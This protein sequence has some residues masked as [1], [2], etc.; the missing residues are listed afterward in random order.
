M[1]IGTISDLDSEGLFGLIDCDDGRLV[2]FNLWDIDPK[3][4][5]IF[6]IG[7]R[8]SFVDAHPSIAPR[9]TCLSR[10]SHP[11]PKR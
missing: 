3:Q 8:V 1:P 5:P 2:L 6:A 10:H 9:A 11:P 7:T 4:R